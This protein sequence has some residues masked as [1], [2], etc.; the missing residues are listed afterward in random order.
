M[1]LSELIFILI[2]LGSVISL[3]LSPFLRRT[4]AFRKILVALVFVWGVYFAIL[5]VTDVLGVQQV[6]KVGEDQCFDEMCFAVSDVQ[7]LPEQVFIPASNSASRLYIVKIRVTSHSRGRAQAEGGLRGRLFDDDVYINV[8]ETAQKAYDAQHGESP[9]LTQRIAPGEIVLSVL[10]F[11]VPQ[12]MM[13]PALT[14]DHGITPGY[15]V[16]GESPFLHQP[17]IHELP[18]TR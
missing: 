12:T 10:V 8:S 15:F 2:F 14:L 1:T 6:F 3:L 4:G 18:K 17:D 7:T 13:Q 11:E 16:I 5:A 9:R